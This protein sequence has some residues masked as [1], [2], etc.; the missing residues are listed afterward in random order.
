VAAEGLALV[1]IR[2][3][4]VERS[5][6]GARA[7][8]PPTFRLRR[9]PPI[10]YR[11]YGFG[12]RRHCGNPD[13][14]VTFPD[15]RE[16]LGWASALAVEVKQAHLSAIPG[17]LRSCKAAERPLSAGFVCWHL[18]RREPKKGSWRDS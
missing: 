2:R 11:E 9:G 18:G 5:P 3:K 16:E 1:T 14:I 13:E 17:A 7:V 8:S 12:R 15:W 10:P 4:Q 6:D